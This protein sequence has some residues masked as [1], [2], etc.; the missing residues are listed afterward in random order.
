VGGPPPVADDGSG[1]DEDPREPSAAADAA[2]AADASVLAA[3][4]DAADVDA[5]Q[6]V[7]PATDHPFGRVLPVRAV[8][9]GRSRRVA[10]RLFRTPPADAAG[11]EAALATQV[12]RWASAGSLAGV[13]PVHAAG[14][15]S[16]PWACTTPVETPLAA[17]DHLPL[18]RA[19]RDARALARALAGLHDRGVVHAGL[20]PTTV[21][22]GA[23]G[24]LLVDAVGLVDVYRRFVDPASVLDPRYAAPEYFEA[25]RGIVDRATDV[26]H[27]GTVLFRLLT[28]VAPYDGT[29]HAVREGVLSADPV[30]APSTVEPRVPERLDR[31]VARATAPD[32]FERFESGSELLAAVEAVCDSVLA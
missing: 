13:V 6:P 4:R 21:G 31:V 18:T 15:E 3:V 22:Y 8:E 14:D 5:L 1:R 27:F 7:G 28:G 20:D 23:D 2:P 19:L 29:A 11:F 16:R 12:D 24:D 9:D 25:D 32:K 26:Y 30:M 10:V 17:R